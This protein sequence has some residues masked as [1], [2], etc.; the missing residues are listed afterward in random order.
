MINKINEF[1]KEKRKG[2]DITL[3]WLYNLKEASYTQRKVLDGPVISE[4][5]QIRGEA[6]KD[7]NL[8]INGNLTDSICD[9]TNDMHINI[10]DGNDNGNQCKVSAT[11]HDSNPE[12]SNKRKRRP[13]IRSEDFLWA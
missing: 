7:D 5:H 10:N 6:S 11:I 12:Y 1:S 13:P 3:G 8:N 2:D 9:R 4:A